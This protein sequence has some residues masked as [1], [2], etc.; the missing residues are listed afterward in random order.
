MM[1]HYFYFLAI[2]TTQINALI[3]PIGGNTHTGDGSSQ[4][5]PVITDFLDH[6]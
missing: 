2:L 1:E 5:T 6:E 4:R 3:P